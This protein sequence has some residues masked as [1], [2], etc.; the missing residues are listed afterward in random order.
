[1]ALRF[2]LDENL[3]G[4]LWS[5]L[6]RHTLTGG[7]PVDAVRVGDASD[8]PLGSDDAVVLAWAEREGRILVTEDKH[9]M[10]KHLAVHLQAGRDSPGVF[11]VRPGFSISQLVVFLELAAHA[12]EPGEFENVITFIP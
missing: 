1:M 8:L 11:M 4:P 3:R 2:L 10:A 7:M 9:T 6:M 5:A 12:G